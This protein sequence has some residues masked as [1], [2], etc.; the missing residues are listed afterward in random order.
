M[1]RLGGLFHSRRGFRHSLDAERATGCVLNLNNCTLK[2]NTVFSHGE[3]LRRVCEKSFD[4]WL[5]FAPQHTLLW[6]CKTCVAQVSSATGE[7]LF[8]SGLHVRMRTDDRA[9]AAIEHAGHR[10][11]LGGRLRMNVHEDYLRLRAEAGDG[12]TCGRKRI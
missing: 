3:A 5:D 2:K 6:P 7:N 4:H 12:L 11:F 10:Y 9:H 1:A 8:I